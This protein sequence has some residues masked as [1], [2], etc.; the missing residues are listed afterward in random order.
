MKAD[1][2]TAFNFTKLTKKGEGNILY[3]HERRL[4]SPEQI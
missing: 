2:A 1:A 4:L 3:V